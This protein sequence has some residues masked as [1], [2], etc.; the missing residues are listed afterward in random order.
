MLDLQVAF[1]TSDFPTKILYVPLYSPIGVTYP[2]FSFSLIWLA[3]QCLVKIQTMNF[4]LYDFLSFSINPPFLVQ[5][6]SS[7][8]YFQ[9]TQRMLEPDLTQR[10]YPWLRTV[11]AGLWSYS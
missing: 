4:S 3:E 6:P 7:V 5:I 8:P 2:A 11:R 9:I 10:K 1:I